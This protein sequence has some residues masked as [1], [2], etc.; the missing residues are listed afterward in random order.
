MLFRSALGVTGP[1]T[2]AGIASMATQGFANIEQVVNTHSLIVPKTVS[3][4]IYKEWRDILIRAATAKS[5]QSSYSN[6][7]CSALT[8]NE[9]QSQ[10]WFDSQMMLWKKLSQTVSISTK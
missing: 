2:V 8:L 4:A 5:V 1:R 6:D 3:D 7:F 9:P 10:A